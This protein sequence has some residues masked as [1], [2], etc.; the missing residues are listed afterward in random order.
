MYRPFRAAWA[1]LAIG[2]A[3]AGGVATRGPGFT[4]ITFIGRDYLERAGFTVVTAASGD[5]ALRVAHQQRPDLVVL[6]LGLPVI[7]GLDVA[8]ALRRDGEVPII[9]LTARADESDRVAGLELG[10]DDY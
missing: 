6:D 2:A 4:G 8:R 3:T 5:D 9:M 10:A 1:L 7:D